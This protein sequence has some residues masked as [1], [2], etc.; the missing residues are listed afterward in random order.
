MEVGIRASSDK[1][2][3]TTFEFRV[4]M[5][6]TFNI[7]KQK[8][9]CKSLLSSCWCSPDVA[10]SPVSGSRTPAEADI[11][12]K[13]ISRNEWNLF[14]ADVL[15]WG[16]LKFYEAKGASWLK[17]CG[18][19]LCLHFNSAGRAVLVKYISLNI[20]QFL[21]LKIWTFEHLNIWTFVTVITFY[22]CDCFLS[23]FYKIKFNCT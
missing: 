17:V 23:F 20:W 18:M 12:E 21:Y 2:C 10:W 13:M 22:L 6:L 3:F 4:K 1:L 15:V 5:S 8:T 9:F 14:D 7:S 19:S 11:F 16:E